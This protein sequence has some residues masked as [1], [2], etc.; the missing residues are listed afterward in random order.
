MQATDKKNKTQK[1]NN[2]WNGFYFTAQSVSWTHCISMR[3]W[4]S[5]HLLSMCRFL[6]WFPLNPSNRYPISIRFDI[7]SHDVENQE[8]IIGLKTNTNTNANIPNGWHTVCVSQ[9]T[10]PL[11]YYYYPLDEYHNRF[12]L[13]AL[14]NTLHQYLCIDT[15]AT[16][17]N[18]F[19]CTM[20][21]LFG[22]FCFLFYY[23]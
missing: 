21:Y 23:D 9:R 10:L 3:M 8:Q 16:A 4:V 1:K 15:K 7:H 12:G 11:D 2:R 14:A 18:L 17:T 13:I 6:C 5:F 19:G 22:L 20:P